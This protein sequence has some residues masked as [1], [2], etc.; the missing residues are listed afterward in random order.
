LFQFTKS[1]KV[2][3]HSFC[4]GEDFNFVVCTNNLVTLYDVKISKQKAKAIKQIP[5]P[6][7]DPIVG[8][9]FEP[10]AN[11]L[12]L[13]DAKALVTVFY[14]NLHTAKTKTGASRLQK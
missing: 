12:T 10:M 2:L 8:C 14:L 9:Y 6:Q 3:L 5:V 1:Q 11:V 13:V 7:G 4:L